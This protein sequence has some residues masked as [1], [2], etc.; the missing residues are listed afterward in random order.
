MKSPSKSLAVLLL[1]FTFFVMCT[2]VTGNPTLHRDKTLSL[3]NTEI[4]PELRAKTADGDLM[5]MYLNPS[6][7]LIEYRGGEQFRRT[8]V[9]E[10]Y[11]EVTCEG[12]VDK[13]KLAENKYNV[14]EKE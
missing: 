3:Y 4:V 8:I 12:R 1:I 13:Y 6:F 5:L 14:K 10:G 11:I 9:S 2:H 7:T